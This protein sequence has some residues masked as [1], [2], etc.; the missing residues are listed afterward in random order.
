[1]ALTIGRFDDT[2]E[3]PETILGIDLGT[4][5]SLVAISEKGVPRIL[6]DEKGFKLIP[7]IIYWAQGA[8]SPIIGNEAKPY[9]VTDATHTASS[10]KRFMGRG[11]ADLDLQSLSAV[12]TSLSTNENILI[13][14]GE[15]SFSAIEL[16]SEVLKKL[17]AIAE[18]DIKTSVSKAV[19]TVPAYFNDAQ[20]SATR[21]AGQLAGLDV[22]RIVNEPTAAAL[23]Y[24]LDKKQNGLIAVYDLGGGTFDISILKL[25]DGIFEVL[26]TNGD[27]SLGGDDFDHA[28][29]K[30]IQ[31]QIPEAALAK[32]LDWKA[33]VVEFAETLKKDLSKSEVSTQSLSFK[34]EDYKISVT[35]SEFEKSI[36]HF[37][38]KTLSITTLA[39]S[40]AKID[41][42]SIGDIV[43]VGGSTR[44]PFVRETLRAFF[45]KT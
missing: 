4:T 19:V 15:R 40:D 42:K 41:K 38:E 39:L 7:S 34:G 9:R 43:M 44:V 36:A 2:P 23:A 26:A 17:K 11:K 12:D 35:R 32:D 33:L 27:T 24:G 16:S 20:R 29:V 31:K 13:K 25:H 10:V 3:I 21:L 28:L 5:N 14:L 8:K 22:V 45:E 1:M 37:V 18:A 6:K 30:L